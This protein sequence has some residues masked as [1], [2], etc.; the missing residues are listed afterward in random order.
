M[1]APLA[2]GPFKK[3]GVSGNQYDEPES[4][5][6]PAWTKRSYA[7]RFPPDTSD[8]AARSSRG[9]PECVTVEAG[10]SLIAGRCYREMLLMRRARKMAQT[11]MGGNIVNA[12]IRWNSPLYERVS[13]PV[14]PDMIG[15][16]TTSKTSVATR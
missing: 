14:T 3:V 6:A 7:R 13:S 16:I 5:V 4:A 12:K 2:G 10:R 9:R 11:A 1:V 15:I 8:P